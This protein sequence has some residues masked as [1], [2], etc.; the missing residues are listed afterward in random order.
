MFRCQ[1]HRSGV[2]I[3]KCGHV[4]QFVRFDDFEG[5]KLCWVHIENINTF[6][7]EIRDIKRYVA[8]FSVSIKFI[9]K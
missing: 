7:R 3:V 9:S 8:V 6:K 5:A 2:F 4:S 1:R